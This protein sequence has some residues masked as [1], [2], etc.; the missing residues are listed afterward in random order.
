MVGL[1]PAVASASTGP[2]PY[3]P[4]NEPN[5]YLVSN[6]ATGQ[7]MWFSTVSQRWET[8]NGP[9]NYIGV[10]A[11]AWQHYYDA[12][13]NGSLNICIFY[14]G[15]NFLYDKGCSGTAAS[16]LWSSQFISGDES[17]NGGTSGIWTVKNKYTGA[18]KCMQGPAN[19]GGDVTMQTCDG[20]KDQEW[21]WLSIQFIANSPVSGQ[22]ASL[23]PHRAAYR[24][25]S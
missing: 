9:Y 16:N 12:A 24:L 20:A 5:A 13:P 11:G 25:A 14:A 7:N 17:G 15:S 6:V 18:T 19:A 4:A 2:T 3:I 23:A 10:G 1:T 8:T 21:K 22:T